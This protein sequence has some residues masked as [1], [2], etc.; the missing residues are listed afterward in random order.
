MLLGK[1]YSKQLRNIGIYIDAPVLISGN[2][3]IG[4]GAKIFSNISLFNASIG[5]Y[6]YTRSS[7][8]L[9]HIGNYCSIAQSVG[10]ACPHP[11]NRLTTS[12]L[13]FHDPAHEE[14]FQKFG[15]K[16]NFIYPADT[17]IG[18]DVWL[19]MNVVLKAGIKIGNGVIVGAG[20]VV[21]RDIPD[22]AVVAGVPAKIIKMRFPDRLIEKI[23]KS[24][25]FSYD[26]ADLTINWSHPESAIDS[27]YDH[28][29]RNTVHS[30]KFYEYFSDNQTIR[31]KPLGKSRD[32]GGPTGRGQQNGHL[33]RL[34]G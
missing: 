14:V 18:H 30:A 15:I 29:E 13:T 11:M 10:V 9:C 22:F 16:E 8:I 33:G 5:A 23:S 21:T 12:P 1:E 4:F 2:G 25:W 28:I 26:W 24:N 7:L 31:F 27:M 20:A 6:S 34:P 17:H 19:G 3:H 32:A